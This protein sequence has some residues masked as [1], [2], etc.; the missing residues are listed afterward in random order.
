MIDSQLELWIPL[1]PML[2][3]LIVC[4]QVARYRARVT[5]QPTGHFLAVIFG[6]VIGFFAV[7]MVILR[8]VF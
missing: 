6:F 2:L 5:S 7:M 1:L 3:G 4:Y 8:V